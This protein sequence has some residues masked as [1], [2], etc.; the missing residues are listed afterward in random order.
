MES[1]Y[2]RLGEDVARAGECLARASASAE[3]EQAVLGYVL[4]AAY[5]LR[6]AIRLEDTDRTLSTHNREYS[7]QLSRVATELAAS[8]RITAREW[9]AGFYFNVAIEHLKASEDRLRGLQQRRPRVARR[10]QRASSG[11]TINDDADRLKHEPTGLISGRGATLDEG[12]ARLL[13]V[14]EKL[15]AAFLASGPGNP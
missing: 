13:A 14:A 11:D 6:C 3:A 9:L 15:D 7:D 10:A 1:D 12:V 8:D 2:E 4:G 5:A